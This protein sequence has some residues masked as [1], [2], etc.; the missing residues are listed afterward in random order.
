MRI[1]KFQ[2]PICDQWFATVRVSSYPISFA[3]VG[4]RPNGFLAAPERCLGMHKVTTNYTCDGVGVV[5][6]FM[7]ICSEDEC[8]ASTSN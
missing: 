6:N 8:Q 7:Q 3:T 2:V 4:M 1:P 5:P